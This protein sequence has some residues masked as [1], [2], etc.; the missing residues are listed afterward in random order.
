MPAFLD[1]VSLPVAGTYT[2]D[3]DPTAGN[4]GSVTLNLYDVPADV[5]GSITQGGSP[6][7]VTLG[8]PGQNGA[9]TFSGTSAERISLKISSAPTGTIQIRRS[10]GTSVASASM[11]P[12]AAFIDT[13]ALPATDTYSI[14]VDPAGANT[15]TVTLT[16]YDVPADGS[17]TLTVNGSA[18]GVAL[19]TPGQN[20]AYTFAGTAGQTATVHVTSNTIGNVLVKLL[21]PDG[22]QLTST[23]SLLA[24]FNLSQQTLPTTGT[25]T[26]IVDPVGAN[27]GSMNLSVTHP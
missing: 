22:S 26:V 7:A 13:T 12:V 27:A 19:S 15:G 6:V 25:Y 2:V 16:L 21:K 17:G 10:N 4:T 24:S 18:I 9:L 23:T 14:V 3:V 5:S 11:G 8:T 20:G 1:T